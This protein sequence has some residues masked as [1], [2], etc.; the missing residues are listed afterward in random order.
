[1]L[2]IKRVHLYDDVYEWQLDGD[3]VVALPLGSNVSIDIESA[4]L[5]LKVTSGENYVVEIVRNL[6]VN[7]Q[8]V[9]NSVPT[10]IAELDIRQEWQ[11][12]LGVICPPDVENMMS[13]N[14]WS[15][16]VITLC[17]YKSEDKV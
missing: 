4:K 3:T 8:H 1:M 10:D 12:V 15:N 6:I 7:I 9:K 17:N 13:A 14:G 5:T 11:D 16:T 2:K